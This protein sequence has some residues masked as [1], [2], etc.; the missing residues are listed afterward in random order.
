M[1]RP[2]FTRIFRENYTAEV[3]TDRDRKST[4]TE[5]FGSLLNAFL[6]RICQLLATIIPVNMMKEVGQFFD[7][8]RPRKD[9]NLNEVFNNLEDLSVLGNTPKNQ[10]YKGAFNIFESIA[11]SNPTAKGNISI[12]SFFIRRYVSVLFSYVVIRVIYAN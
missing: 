10:R 4:T 1:I 12:F 9:V 8:N 2:Q 6:H 7:K 11:E 3:D 5:S